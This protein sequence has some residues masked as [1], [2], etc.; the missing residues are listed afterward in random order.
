MLRHYDIEDCLIPYQCF[1]SHAW[2]RS[3][4]EQYVYICPYDIHT[5]VH[6]NYH[7]N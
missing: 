6:H 2:L 5:N 3:W 7:L 1:G 4:T